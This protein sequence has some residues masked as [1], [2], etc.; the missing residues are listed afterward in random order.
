MC[1]CREGYRGLGDEVVQVV[2]NRLLQGGVGL[3][4]GDQNGEVSFKLVCQIGDCGVAL[5][6]ISFSVEKNLNVVGDKV[7]ELVERNES[8]LDVSE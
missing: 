4:R 5:G 1:G 3:H 6:E 7:A 8:G 2:Q